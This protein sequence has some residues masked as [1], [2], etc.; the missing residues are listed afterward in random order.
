MNA[1]ATALVEVICQWL[2]IGCVWH[3]LE[4]LHGIGYILW[5]LWQV[6]WGIS[7]VDESHMMTLFREHPLWDAAM[8]GG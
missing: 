5:V 8:I 1:T 4:C 3:V 7:H 2:F 6:V